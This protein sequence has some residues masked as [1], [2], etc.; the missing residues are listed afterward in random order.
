MVDVFD[1]ETKEWKWIGK[2]VLVENATTTT[3]AI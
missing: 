3:I 2:F 1:K